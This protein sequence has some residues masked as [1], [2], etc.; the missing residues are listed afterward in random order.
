MVCSWA[1]IT[2]ETLGMPTVVVMLEELGSEGADGAGDET[3]G[4][5][6]GGLEIGRTTI[7]VVTF[8]RDLGP[9]PALW[10]EPEPWWTAFP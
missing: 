6:T 3:G 1:V 4:D 2:E 9:D 5:E 8:D 7:G 10:F